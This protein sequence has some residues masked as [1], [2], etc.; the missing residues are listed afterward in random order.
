MN[1]ALY[2]A[3]QIEDGKVSYTAIFSK[4][5]WQKYQEEVDSIL[6]ADGKQDLIVQ[7]V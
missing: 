3:A 2:I 1:M 4:K 5:M 7:T 6:I